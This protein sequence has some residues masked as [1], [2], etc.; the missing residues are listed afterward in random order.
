MKTMMKK[1]LAG[2]AVAAS[3]FSLSAPASATLTNWYLDTDGAG[4]AA[5]VQVQDYWI[6]TGIVVCQQYVFQPQPF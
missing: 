2:A 3:L 4:G 1:L 6:V 5:P